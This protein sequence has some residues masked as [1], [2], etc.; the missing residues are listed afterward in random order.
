MGVLEDLAEE[1]KAIF[2]KLAAAQDK[3]ADLKAAYNR[4]HYGGQSPSQ[5]SAII[6]PFEDAV[7][8]FASQLS[9]IQY[10]IQRQ[11]AAEASVASSFNLLPISTASPAQQQA[12]TQ[13][14]FD[15]ILTGI[16]S[17]TDSFTSSQQTIG[18][19]LSGYN[20]TVSASLNQQKADITDAF[21]AQ[22]ANVADVVSAL[23]ATPTQAIPSVIQ[24]PAQVSSSLP[25][26]MIIGVGGIAAFFLVRRL[27]LI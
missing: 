7:S 10:T 15:Q 12:A 19:K 14:F 21:N 11:Q 18:E 27:K 20:D 16:K 8:D 3:V 9:N 2:D 5:F 17:L 1:Q 26:I 6:K 25:S 4:D 24:E 23:N 13:G 22:S